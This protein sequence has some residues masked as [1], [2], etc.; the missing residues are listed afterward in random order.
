[1]TVIGQTN[2]VTLNTGSN[3][4]LLF[5]STGS[6]NIRIID[7]TV[8]SQDFAVYSHYVWDF[9]QSPFSIATFV[10]ITDDPEVLDDFT[11]PHITFT[12]SNVVQV[13]TSTSADELVDFFINSGSKAG[14]SDCYGGRDIT[15]S[16][17]ILPCLENSNGAAF[18]NPTTGDIT[19]TVLFC[20]LACGE[21]I[22]FSVGRAVQD[23]TAVSFAIGINQNYT[24]VSN[25]IDIVTVALTSSG[26]TQ[27]YTNAQSLNEVVYFKFTGASIPNFLESST[28]FLD[29]IISSIQGTDTVLDVRAFDGSSCSSFSSSQDLCDSVSA[30]GSND[31]CYLNFDPCSFTEL[32]I[33]PTAGNGFYLRISRTSG[34]SLNW[35]FT[36]RGTVTTATAIDASETTATLDDETGYSY[37]AIKDILDGQWHFYE[38]NIDNGDFGGYNSLDLVISDIFCNDNI[39]DL[40]VYVSWLED[41][42]GV[43]DVARPNRWPTRGC[44]VDNDVDESSF[45]ISNWCNTWGGVYR[46]ALFANF[47][48][49]VYPDPVLSVTYPAVYSIDFSITVNVV[50]TEIPVNCE[51]LVTGGDYLVVRPDA[52]NRGTRLVFGLVSDDGS[53][54]TLWV[55]KN[56]NPFETSAN[57]AWGVPDS[58]LGEP[59]TTI[60]GDYYCNT[61]G[62]ACTIFIDICE[63]ADDTWF[64]YIDAIQG[65]DHSLYVYNNRVYT[66]V[67]ALATTGFSYSSAALVSGSDYQFYNFIVDD[68]RADFFFQFT[69]Y[70]VECNDCVVSAFLLEGPHG[71]AAGN[72]ANGLG[73]SQACSSCDFGDCPCFD[74]R[75]DTSANGYCVLYSDDCTVP[76]QQLFI[77]VRAGEISGGDEPN[78]PYLIDVTSA[79]VAVP[80]VEE[81]EICTEVYCNDYYQLITS[82]GQTD[83]TATTVT[84]VV[85]NYDSSDSIAV[86]FNYDHVA[87]PNCFSDA[88]VCAAGDVCIYDLTCNIGSI[89]VGIES[90]NC[91][92]TSAACQGL[93]YSIAYSYSDVTIGTASVGSTVQSTGIVQISSNSPFY[94]DSAVQVTG[95]GA[96]CSVGCQTS[97]GAG[98]YYVIAPGASFSAFQIS[99]LSSTFST[100]TFDADGI[101]FF[102][103]SVPAGVDGF[104]I[105]FQDFAAPAEFFDYAYYWNTDFP[106]IP[107]DTCEASDDYLV[108]GSCVDDAVSLQLTCAEQTTYYLTLVACDVDICAQSFRARV[109]FNEARSLIGTNHNGAYTQLI[110]EATC[111]SSSGSYGFYTNANVHY[112]LL[113]VNLVLKEPLL[114]FLCILLMNVHLVLPMDVLLLLLPLVIKLLV[115]FLMDAITMIAPLVCSMLMLI[116]L[117]PLLVLVLNSWLLINMLILLVLFPM[118]SLDKNVTSIVLLTLLTLFPSN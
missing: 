109:I 59:F 101:L 29:L 102:S 96:G 99:S 86:Y 55:S 87:T 51:N 54:S 45:S 61:A 80:L 2:V 52:S 93:T 6:Q 113:F 39:F 100:A 42:N 46:V 71:Y 15:N 104:T 4:N 5:P 75:C 110:R 37:S 7:D 69:I 114:L 20:D 97:F 73:N 105:E 111:E 10:P 14:I 89:Y 53:D 24:A 40:D 57:C 41:S 64:I 63:Y 72:G 79:A 103:V 50:P 77:G 28:Q 16:G 56:A 88:S 62:D 38:F 78:C 18:V 84:V 92:R 3:N 82:D 12:I 33:D 60:N 91:L 67:V 27:T 31:I 95:P 21:E 48:L 43:I 49:Q 66:P 22:Y 98:S 107:C 8:D 58:G 115:V 68:T 11:Y 34:S 70:S 13:G 83:F 17:S 1:L 108:A 9:N 76:S 35:G 90:E 118:F 32:F 25:E 85:T 106:L 117:L 81:I 26:F 30:S 74:Q 94:A 112:M 44:F 19:C 36:L 65:S 23:I 47:G 116:F